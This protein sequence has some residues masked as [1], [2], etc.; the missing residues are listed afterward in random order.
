MNKLTILTDELPELFRIH[1]AID[2]SRGRNRAT[3]QVLQ[4]EAT[5]DMAAINA[6][7]MNHYSSKQ[8]LASY[9]KEAI[10]LFLWAAHERGRSISDLTHKD[11]LAYQQFIENP[12]PASKWVSK[13]LEKDKR[14]PKLPISHPEW[15][16]FYGPLSAASCKQ[17]IV[18]LDGMFSWL[19]NAGY[20]AGNPLALS[21]KRLRGVRGNKRLSRSL[22]PEQIEMV[23]SMISGLPAESDALRKANARRRWVVALLYLTGLRISEAVKNTMGGFHQVT[24]QKGARQ[25]WL[26]AMGKGKRED[27]IPVTP[28][29]MRELAAY[30]SA[31]GLSSTPRSGE[32][33][34]LVFSLGP[35]HLP[36]TRQTLHGIIKSTFDLAAEALLER[37]LEDD[38]FRLEEASAHWLRH[39]LGSNLVRQGMNIAQVRDVMRHANLS[40]TNRYVNTDADERHG[41]MVDKHKLPTGGT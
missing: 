33:L 18:I 38:A 9:R 1:A 24:G 35:S 7:L 14:P 11:M 5:D 40:T 26:D 25:W 23:L 30:R 2:W 22:E 4:I 29:L 15:R 41:E 3:G 10:R 37:G 21:R 12:Q 8:T 13:S 31:F 6:W 32:S 39:S 19:V 36:I 20:L 17:A 16:P 28:D 27:E 34:P